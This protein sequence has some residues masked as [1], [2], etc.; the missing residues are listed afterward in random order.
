MRQDPALFI[1]LALVAMALAIYFVF[2]SSYR[3]WKLM[4]EIEKHRLPG[5]DIAVIRLGWHLIDSTILDDTGKKLRLELLAI[6]ARL[7][8]FA[9]AL[10]I[11]DIYSV[12]QGT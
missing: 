11:C 2:K 8:L 1:G 3:M 7:A 10:I 6:F 9:I 12:R 5:V 4:Q